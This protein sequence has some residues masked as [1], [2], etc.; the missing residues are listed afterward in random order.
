MSSIG[1]SYVALLG[2]NARSSI[3]T[4]KTQWNI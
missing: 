2:A 4:D 3:D 1:L